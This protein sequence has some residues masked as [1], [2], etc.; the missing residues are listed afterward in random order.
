MKAGCRRPFLLLSFGVL[1]ALSGCRH[2][3]SELL[4]A[5]LR[6]RDLQFREALEELGKAEARNQALWFE[7]EAVRKGSKVPPE[8][9]AQTFGL[10]RIVLARGTGGL[11]DDRLPGDE[12]LQ[13]VLEPRD[14]DDHT[15]KAPGRLQ[16]IALEVNS[17]GLKAPLSS[18]TVEPDKLRASWKQGLLS[19]GYNLV[20]PFKNFPQAENLRV[21]ARFTTSDGRVFEADKDIRVRLV[22]GAPHAGPTVTPGPQLDFPPPPNLVDPPLLEP[23]G[24]RQVG[25]SP[26]G[27]IPASAWQ[28]VPLDGA[29]QLGRPIPII[30]PPE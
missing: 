6:A 17:Q 30:G 14:A 27:A 25:S 24:A 7:L 11:D 1:L 8:H 4:E 26:S 2:N 16:V 13:V 22:P 20:L 23:T 5:E 3:N 12:A 28:P 10:R 21:V 9:A 19:T 18:W 29:V 15:I